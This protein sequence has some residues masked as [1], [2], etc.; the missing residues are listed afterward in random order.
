M[1]WEAG[2]VRGRLQQRVEGEKLKLRVTPILGTAEARAQPAPKAQL[3]IMALSVP[4]SEAGRRPVSFPQWSQS[5]AATSLSAVR[6]TAFV[7]EI[8]AFLHVC[9]ARHAPVSIALAREYVAAGTRRDP[10]VAREALRWFVSRG[11]HRPAAPT[12]PAAEPRQGAARRRFRRVQPRAGAA[13]RRRQGR[14]WPR[15]DGCVRPSRRWLG[16]IKAGRTG[17]AT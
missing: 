17:S 14:C 1:A 2:E 5:L 10:V 7:R 12:C 6:R 9:K 13:V 15:I 16:R 3:G 4:D 11:R 8:L